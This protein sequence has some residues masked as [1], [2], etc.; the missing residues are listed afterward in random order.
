VYG[1]TGRHPHPHYVH[2]EPVTSARR[3]QFAWG[4]RFKTPEHRTV[5]VQPHLEYM[6]LRTFDRTYLQVSPAMGEIGVPADWHSRR[7]SCLIRKLVRSHCKNR[8]HRTP[9]Y[10]NPAVRYRGI[11]VSSRAGGYQRSSIGTGTP[12]SWPSISNSSRSVRIRSRIS[13]ASSNSRL[14][15]AARIRS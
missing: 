10:S 14:S 8:S 13:A 4:R 7:R 6:M 5:D 2:T 3:P 11:S 9:Q 15:A 12:S 1:D